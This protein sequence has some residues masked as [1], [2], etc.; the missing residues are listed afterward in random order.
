MQRLADLLGHAIDVRSRPGK[1]TVFTVEVPLVTTMAAARSVR[2]GPVE[3]SPVVPAGAT[4]L[5]VEDDPAV[6]A[7]LKLVLDSEGYR[8][9]TAADGRA[10]FELAREG[11]RPSLVLADYNLPNGPNGLQVVT[12]LQ[13]TLGR[14]IP[15]IILSGDIS[16]ETLRE[17][18]HRGC[19][20][21]AKPVTA[22]T[23]IRLIQDLLAK[24]PPAAGAE[25]GLPA[26]FIVDDDQTVRAALC[27]LLVAHGR[28]VQ[29]YESGEAFLAAYRSGQQG[30]LLV[31]AQLP[32]MSGLELLQRIKDDRHHLPAIMVTGHGDVPMAVQAMKAGAA[33]FVEKPIGYPELL[34]SVSR[35]L[36]Q[37]G[38][39]AK[40]SAWKETAQN[41]IAGLTD[42]Q[43]QVMELVLAGYPSKNIAADL[44]V[45]QRT[46]ENHR[47]AVMKKTGSRSIP[48]LI[49]LVLAAAP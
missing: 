44:G 49:R 8:T 12:T 38:D 39:T 6:R 5:V 35:A 28:T 3:A 10:A 46:V 17:I 4:I 41:S 9:V 30:C 20:Y 26:I 7:L 31:D 16:T 40:A 25:S 23:L 2:P 11:E 43:R 45:S 18:A 27:D 48:A 24:T 36:E 47:A 29:T 33:D 15:A 13:E 19:T 42:R 37:A 32:G 34:A 21:L 1:G 22:P 14:N